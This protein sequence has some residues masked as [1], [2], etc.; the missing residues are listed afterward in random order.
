MTFASGNMN[1]MKQIR[2][3]YL[4]Y[5]ISAGLPSARI[6]P[7]YPYAHI[8]QLGIL[9]ELPFNLQIRISIQ[10]SCLL[11]SS[12]QRKFYLNI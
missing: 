11:G 5:F 12:F 8:I 10:M 3:Y 4:F 1:R 6:R 2:M 9:S 7:T